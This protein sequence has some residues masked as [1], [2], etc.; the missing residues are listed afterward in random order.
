MSRF[1][2]TH[3]ICPGVFKH[4]HQ[5][6]HHV[7]LRV[8][9][10]HRLVHTR[11]LPLPTVEFRLKIPSVALPQGNIAAVEAFGSLHPAVGRGDETVFFRG[12]VHGFGSKTRQPVE[13][14]ELC[15]E[16]YL[17]ILVFCGKRLAEVGLD[18]LHVVGC[19]GNVGRAVVAF[20]LHG[21]LFR[22]IYDFL[23]LGICK[24]C[25]ARQMCR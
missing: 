1:A 15:G 10:F 22:V 4:G 25:H 2:R 14:A 16:R 8:E 20:H 23:N 6:R 11:A 9:V 17:V 24:P 3:H 5:E 12:G 19:E 21:L 18:L 13:V 7:A